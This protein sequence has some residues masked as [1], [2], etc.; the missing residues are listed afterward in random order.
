MPRA[1]NY[2][3]MSEQNGKQKILSAQTLVPVGFVIVLI[4]L[5]FSFGIAQARIDGLE[6]RT[7]KIENKLDQLATKSDINEIKQDIKDLR[8]LIQK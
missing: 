7:E 2:N 5:A 4:G 6:V 1:V 8:V 3:L